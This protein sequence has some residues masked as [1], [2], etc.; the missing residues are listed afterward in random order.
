M[1]GFDKLEIVGTPLVHPSGTASPASTPSTN[2]PCDTVLC[3]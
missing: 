1:D 2:A 3:K